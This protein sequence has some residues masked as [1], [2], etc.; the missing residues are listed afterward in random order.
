MLGIYVDGE[1]LAFLD[2]SKNLASAIYIVGEE[3][4]D[5]WMDGWMGRWMK[6]VY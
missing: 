4:M 2:I 5:R 1:L 6:T 3:G